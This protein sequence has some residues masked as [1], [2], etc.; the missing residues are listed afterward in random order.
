VSL[1]FLPTEILCLK[2]H[3]A[4]GG[5]DITYSDFWSA[6]SPTV[7]LKTTTTT[8][9]QNKTKENQ[10]DLFLHNVL[11]AKPLAPHSTDTSVRFPFLLFKK[12]NSSSD[13][14]CLQGH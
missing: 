5:R 7:S 1:L 6:H 8:T 13:D 3:A 4:G 14:E 2:S 10:N 9:K 12:L 11:E